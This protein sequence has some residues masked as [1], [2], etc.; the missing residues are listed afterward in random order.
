LPA[1]WIST[2]VVRSMQALKV[3]QEG[4]GAVPRNSAAF[5]QLQKIERQLCGS[6]ARPIQKGFRTPPKSGGQKKN[7]A[8]PGRR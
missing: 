4:M 7:K 2:R 3:I 1:G 6:G 5:E 8:K